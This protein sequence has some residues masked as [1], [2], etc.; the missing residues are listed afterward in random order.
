MKKYIAF[1]LCLIM[2][3]SLFSCGKENISQDTNKQ[4]QN[5]ITENISNNVSNNSKSANYDSVLEIYRLIV[6]KIPIVNQNPR[7]LAFELG[8]Q[9]EGEK[10]SFL[11]LYSSIHQFYPSREQ[12]DSLS[13]HYKL[14]CGYAIKDLNGDGVDE[15]VL[16]TDEYRIIAVY[17]LI[18]D[19]PT[20]LGSYIKRDLGWSFRNWIDAEGRIHVVRTDGLDLYHHSIFEISNGHLIELCTYGYDIF[21]ENGVIV[22]KLYQTIHDNTVFITEQEVAELDRQYGN[23][24]NADEAG[25]ITMVSAKLTF[26]SLYTEA[27][28]AMEMYEAAINDKICVIDEH[29]GEIKLKACRFPSNNARIDE[30]KLLTKAILDLDGDGINEYVIQSPDKDHIVLHYYGGKVFSYCFDK[31]NFY[32][33]NADGSFYWSD[34][35]ESENWTHG[36][37]QITFDGESLNIKE[38]YRIKHITPFDFYENLEFYVDGKQITREEFLDYHKSGTLVIFSPLDISC[39]YPISSEK[40]CEIASNYW[41]IENG[42]SEGAAGTQILHKIVILEKPNSDTQGYRISWQ[43]EGYRN[44]VPDPPYSL[45]PENV[46]IHKELF[47]D[48]I[49]GECRE[50]TDSERTME[51]YEQ[52]LSGL[53]SYTTPY[54]G[55]PL[56]ECENLGYAYVDLDGDSINEL[57]I[58]CGD[59][60]ILRYYEGCV[61]VYPFTFRGINNLHT[62]GSYS[63]NDTGV[64]FEYGED[65][66]AFDG[67]ELRTKELWRIVND[68]EPNAEYYIDGKQVTQEEILKYFEDNPKT[69]IEFSPLE[70]SW[71]SNEYPNGKG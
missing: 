60:L 19:I 64:N 11:R 13:P 54:S 4:D 56:C 62:D 41:K 31:N 57:V 29:L 49:T 6:E 39:E 25:N 2:I 59:T 65:Q 21:R 52:T 45:P 47:V 17:S 12:E 32:N 23:P 38:I 20:L 22:G 10:E 67:A 48:A 53:A 34:S 61:Y 36:L 70:V 8:I 51:M 9:D 5:E 28:I 18:N 69:K 43:W 35:Y 40:A 42:M 33:L 50:Y 55:I 1:L 44:H 63:W 27:E 68:G 30:C 24:I 71:E 66:L 37:N 46:I 7:A 58:D 14:G 26:T 16:L 15:L 3:L